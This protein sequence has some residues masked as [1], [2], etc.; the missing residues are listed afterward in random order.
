MRDVVEHQP[1]NRVHAQRV[2]A[3]GAGN[4][5][6]WLLSGWKAERNERL[7]PPVFIRHTLARCSMWSTRSSFVSMW[8]YS[9]VT[10]VHA[11]VCAVR[12]IEVT[13]RIALVGCELL[14]HARRRPRHRHHGSESK[15]ASRSSDNT[16]S[17]VLP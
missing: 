9:M 4:L 10:F 16:C 2:G 14:A 5:R 15:P 12:W 17:S 7:K 6:I 13:V 8:P 11:I 3:V 1:A